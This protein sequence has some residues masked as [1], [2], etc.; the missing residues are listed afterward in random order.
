MALQNIK[1]IAEQFGTPLYIYEAEKIKENLSTILKFTTYPK[2][3]VY[4]AAM[5]N[6]QP[7]ILKIIK[8]S[9]LGV[10][11]N[12][13]H[14]LNTVKEIGFDS[15]DIS[16]TSAG[17]SKELIKK[18]IE[19][20]IETNLDSVEEVG[21]FCTSVK[22]RT[23]GIRVRISKK[24]KI[25]SKK[26]SNT[27]LD[28]HMGIE[29]KDFNKIKKIAKETDNRIT[30]V[31]G[32]FAS[33]VHDTKPFIEFGNFLVSTALEFPDLEYVNFGSGFGVKYSEK[34]KD[35]DFE[36]VLQYYSSLLIKLSKSLKREITLK[37][38]PGR[39]ILA[40]AGT[41]LVRITNIKNLNPG[42]SEISVDAGFAEFARPIIYYSYHEIENLE[43]TG[44]PKKVYDIRGN[45]VLQ[46]DFLGHDRELEEVREGDYL[47]IKKVGAYGIVMASGFPGKKLPKQILINKEKIEVL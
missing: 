15:S 3:K 14:E 47:V 6:N 25:N 36:K 23:F 32:Y 7:E 4:F 34:D 8:G 35:L 1:R 18:L 11:V 10:Q 30:G 37:I 19:E 39:F 24:I 45:T 43:N 29:E 28:S 13:D 2:H 41:L 22:D 42:K 38:E 5:C 20:N 17:I 16:F 31:H 44:K 12:S 40:D 21:K 9:G 26:T 33:N 27:Y 46:N